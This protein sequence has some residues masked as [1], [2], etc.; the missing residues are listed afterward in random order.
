VPLPF[1][2]FTA[3]ALVGLLAVSA[4]TRPA[5]A[6]PT[7]DP[8]AT[9]TASSAAR[10]GTLRVTGSI[11]P[12]GR[13]EGVLGR[14]AS[15]GAFFVPVGPSDTAGAP[16][17]TVGRLALVL[18]RLG[19]GHE[20]TTT[21]VGTADAPVIDLHIKLRAADRIR[22]IFI[23][24]NWPLRQEDIIRRLTLRPG[25]ALPDPG[26]DRARRMEEE[27][28]SVLDFLR[29]RG[30][31]DAKVRLELRS[32]QT[33]PTPVS[34]V[35]WITLG[36]GYDIDPIRVTGNRAI[37]TSDIESRFRHQDW[38]TFWLLR[39]PF[40]R[41]LLRQDLRGLTEEYRKR[42]YAQARVTDQIQVTPQNN[43]VQLS[44]SILERKRVVVSFEG[45]RQFSE[46]ELK[47]ALTIFSQGSYS[48][49]ETQKSADA[50]AQLYRGKGYL[51]AQ[52]TWRSDG[53]DAH[54]HRIRFNIIEGPRLKVRGVAFV[55]TKGKSPGALADVVTVKTF[56]LLGVIGI[57]EGGYAS[58]RQLELDVDRLVA[59]YTADG[60]PG[61]TVR[62]EIAPARN[63][64]F[65]LAEAL[66]RKESFARSTELYVRFVINEA[67]RI[68]IGAVGFEVTTGD[69]LPVPE[70]TLRDA[71]DGKPGKPLRPEVIRTDGERLRRLLG[72]AGFPDASVEP[73]PVD[74]PSGGKGITYQIR[75]GAPKRVGPLFLRGNFFTREG[76]IRRWTLLR[77]GAPLTISNL[78]RS[79]RNLAL[80]QVLNNPNPISLLPEAE[81]D[82]TVPVLVEVEERYD[83]LGVVRVGG[84]AS[85]DQSTG[86]ALPFYG[87]VGYEH[88]NL[89]GQSWILSSRAEIGRSRTE[90][91]SDFAYPRFLG[92]KLRLRVN[93]SYL[94]QLTVRLGD[95]RTGGGTIGFAREV[96]PGIDVTFQYALRSTNR[97]ESLLRVAG[98]DI[99]QESVTI[100]TVIGAFGVGLEWQRL[101]SPLVPTRGFRLQAS[102]ELARPSFSFGYG[103][104]SFIKARLGSLNVIPLSRRVSLRHTFRYDQGFPLAGAS[105]LPKVERFFA[106]GDT[107]LRGFALDSARTDVIRAEVAPGVS[108]VKDRPLGGSLRILENVDLQFQVAGPWFASLFV[109]TGVVAEALNGLSASA[110]RHG[111]GIAPLV[112]RLPI[113]DL[114][115]AWAWPLDPAPG[116]SVGG[117]IH[118]NVGLMF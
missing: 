100:N 15:Q 90:V 51:F 73:Y 32:K 80:I 82:G 67:P 9:G 48:S 115:I 6:Q 96:W 3:P 69:A 31:F 36:R 75:L 22:H 93:G 78:E 102:V 58:I 95:L 113:G 109:D 64:Y 45:N 18:E 8:P 40:D 5:A 110:F 74:L 83:H 37:Q 23:V 63:Q 76:T 99:E 55:G 17:S 29:D 108:F 91:I 24:G 30:Y 71:L 66:D 50:I 98:P 94:R 72:D 86:D 101:D 89:F 105:L 70:E 77:E 111:A 92:T 25:Q 116:D 28:L 7:V 13:L 44:L 33:V 34:V 65:P 35:V 21:N 85:T 20:I 41:A 1:S 103:D 114:S 11:D 38:R 79:R 39:L 62:C 53:S 87:A 42:G 81:V 14:I 10:I 56:P 60:F 97:T 61:T 59:H 68:N 112:I 84:G 16:L 57:G 26:S 107:T 47:D 117:R 2:R 118:F 54:E 106:G 27:R 4:L 104:D 46:S 88:R 43:K 19:Y 52:V 12:P 49:F